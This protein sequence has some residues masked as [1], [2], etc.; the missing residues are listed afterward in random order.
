MIT[1]EKSEKIKE[2][3]LHYDASEKLL[4]TE[5]ADTAGELDAQ[6]LETIKIIKTYIE[7]YF[8]N[9]SSISQF[10]TSIDSYNKRNNHWGFTAIKGQMFFNQLVKAG[11]TNEDEL[12]LL[13]KDVIKYPVTID[14]AISKID[15]L[16]KYCLN[17][18][19]KATD[20]RTAPK[21]SSICY[22]LSYFWQ[23]QNYEKWPIMYTSLVSSFSSLNL[24]NNFST[25]SDTYRYFYQLNNEIIAIV[26][27]S[28]NRKINY[29]DI[30]HAFWLYDQ[31][32]NSIKPLTKNENSPQIEPTIN[33]SFNYLEYIIPKLS[34]LIELGADKALSSSKKGYQYEQ[35]V[36]EAFNQLDFDIEQFGQGSGRNPD[37]IAKYRE[38]NTA[39]LIDAKAYSEGYSLGLDD[40]AIKEYITIH[41]PK[42]TKNGY[43]KI[44]FIIVSNSFKSDFDEFV[45]EI[46]WNT[47][48]KRF[49]LITSEALLYL[50]AYKTKDKLS[51][52]DIIES[53]VSIGNPI[54]SDKVIAKF[55]DI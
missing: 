46:T 38:D 21:P 44:G 43:K 45:N 51:L 14:D 20:K 7:D 48:I 18:Y 15:T 32:N 1:V 26:E 37:L 22:F 34:K 47:E 25:Q 27:K 8:Q 31:A 29:W 49:V 30:E 28:A 39:F 33:T 13:V 19:N 17:I 42:L 36:S 50:L 24:W 11:L 3:W 9:N 41:C 10:K 5:S 53:M 4:A 52:K 54:T 6:R 35:M 23:I 12:N 2:I 55:Q 40:R 16:E